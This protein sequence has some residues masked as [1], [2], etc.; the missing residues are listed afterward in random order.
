MQYAHG[1]DV[2][3]YQMQFGG[4]RPLDFSANINPRGIPDAVK[5]AMHRAVDDCTQYPDPQCRALKAALGVRWDLP[6]TAFFCGNGAAEIFYRLVQCIKPRTALLTAPTF[7]EYEQA[8]CG[9]DTEIRFHKLLPEDGFHLTERFLSDLTPDLELVILCTPNNP[10][11]CTVSKALMQQ[12]L[13]RCKENNTWLVVD[14]CFQD[15]LTEPVSMRPYLESYARL[16]IVRAFTKMYAVPGVRL[17]WCMAQNSVLIEQLHTAGQPWNVSVIAEACGLAA[18]SCEGWEQE[19]AVYIKEQREWLTERLQDIGFRVFEAQANYILF[20]TERLDLRE[21]LMERGIMIRSCENYHGLGKG[22]FRTAVRGEQDNQ[23]LIQNM[24]EVLT[25]GEGNYG[26]G[27]GIECR[28]KCDCGC[29]V[30]HF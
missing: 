19:T 10:T 1:G 26:A 16:V 18:L 27:D 28:E 15:F 8:L 5:A 13:E 12:I 22:Y 25:D 3:G 4:R 14:E 29:T 23:T 2:Y 6:S 20:Y 24:Q 9:K 30:P 11:G 21:R 17:G 7:G